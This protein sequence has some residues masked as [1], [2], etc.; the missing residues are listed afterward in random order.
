MRQEPDAAVEAW[1]DRLPA[2][3]VWTT[4]ITVFE[5]SLGL[6][7]LAAG[8]RRRALEDAFAR[9]LAEDFEDRILS[10]DHGAALLAG[11]IAADQR[12]AGK[13]VEIRDVQIAAICAAR[14]AAL[15]TRN[16]RHF[17]GLGL[18]LLN[19]WAQ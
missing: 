12:R 3:S 10:F 17:D 19:P 2:E 18:T 16:T 6:E 7:L 11:H 15:A 14:K 13:P 8:R 5:V 9:A 1:L 4:S